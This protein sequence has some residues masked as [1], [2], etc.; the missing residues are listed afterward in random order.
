MEMR[1][2]VPLSGRN[3]RN[4]G[5]D[6]AIVLLQSSVKSDP[7]KQSWNNSPGTEWHTA[8]D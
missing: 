5:E 8:S 2:E 1:L 3:K 4:S 6:V 7:G